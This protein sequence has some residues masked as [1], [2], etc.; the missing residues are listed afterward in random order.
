MELYKTLQAIFIWARKMDQ[1]YNA[2]EQESIFYHS[3][4]VAVY[5]QRRYY[6]CSYACYIVDWYLKLIL[7]YDEKYPKL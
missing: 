1:N 5:L 3:V 2:R 4:H 7:N 6:I